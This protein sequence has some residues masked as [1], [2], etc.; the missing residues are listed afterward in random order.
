VPTS[1]IAIPSQNLS[2]N[3]VA[4]QEEAGSANRSCAVLDGCATEVCPAT[5]KLA[6]ARGLTRGRGP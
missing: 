4:G 5:M 1:G 3:V 6:G 2:N